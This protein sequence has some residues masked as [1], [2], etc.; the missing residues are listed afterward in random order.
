MSLIDE[1]SFFSSEKCG[2]CGVYGQGFEAS[3]L[4]YFG[5]WALQHRGQESSGI[6]SSDG[7]VIRTHKGEGLVAHVYQ[8]EDL[9]KLKGTMAIGHNRYGTSGGKGSKHAQPI[10]QKGDKVALAHNGTLP[11]TTQLT[12]F[13][14]SKKQNIDGLNDSE[15]MQKA[16]EYY[17]GKGI[18][19][20]LAVK[21]CW[22]LFTGAFCLVLLTKNKLVAI[23]DSCGI[24]PLSF[25]K[26]NGGYV[27]ASETC[28]LDTMS[29]KFVRDIKP[30]EM[31]VFDKKGIHS[32]QIEK[33]Q[34]KL[35]IFE[36]IY[37]A[38]PDSM[39]LGKSVNEVRRNL[40]KLLA[41][42]CRVSADVVIPVPDSAIPAALGFAEASGIPFDHGLI[43]NRYIHRTFIR[44]DQHLRE[45][46][47]RIKLNPLESV[48]K[49]KRV[50][51][52]DDSIVR[53]TTS[54]KLVSILKHA[55]AAKV[56]FL[57]TSSPIR[58]P[59][60]YG[61]DTPSQKDLIAAQLPIEKIQKYIGADSLCYL[62]Y[63]GMVAATG[64]PEGVFSLSSF[65]GDYPID[66]K[67]KKQ[68]ITY[69][70]RRD[71]MSIA[72][73]ISNG[74]T[75]TNLQAIIDAI[76][77]KKFLGKIA[78]VV[79]DTPD[80]QGLVR[81]R[82][83]KIPIRI[84]GKDDNLT[85]LLQKKLPVDY[86]VMA[87]WKKIIPDEFIDAFPKR[88]LNIHPGLIPDT[89][90]GA[91]K[92]PDGTHAL[93]NRGKFTDKAIKAFF[94]KGSTHAGSTVHFLSKEFD[95]GEVLGRCFEKIQSAD[96]VESLYSRLK[97]QEHTLL[98]QVLSKL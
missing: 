82:K 96:T 27:V 2:I 78:V 7:K 69:N 50:V 89:M 37:F 31:V 46:D 77:A 66:I 29:A 26:L 52:V 17:M 1:R 64:L 8:E 94:E 43:K 10:I 9:K 72:V 5:L 98:I 61:I 44:P 74:G 88:I 49:G 32:Y 15:L 68:E 35:D 25:G 62:S 63:Q 20:E 33:G 40:G 4:V 90:E 22:P 70:L 58:F 11:S 23:R 92:N 60:F 84:L 19:I 48:I 91:V 13:L 21:K 47:V 75:G 30:G 53:G 81:A 6:T 79:S 3:R 76:E 73:L 34:Q 18:S 87:G 12:A 67:E 54:K 65:T 97:K 51:V 85:N 83:H 39:L 42:E 93:W 24:R 41:K 71:H 14:L 80:A 28:A 95:F 38:R 45:Q 56:H 59:D 36:F 16:L 57:V 55:G 86:I